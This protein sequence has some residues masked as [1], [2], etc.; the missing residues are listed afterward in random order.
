MSN[1]LRPYGLYSPR[2]NRQ[3]CVL[4]IPSVSDSYGHLI[5]TLF[6][7]VKFSFILC[8]LHIRV[9]KPCSLPHNMVGTPLPGL[10]TSTRTL[11]RTLVRALVRRPGAIMG[12][13]CICI[14][15]SAHVHLNVSVFLCV[16][17]RVPVHVYMCAYMCVSVC[18][19]VGLY[20]CLC[21]WRIT[22]C[23]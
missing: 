21:G 4:R 5:T 23:D 11:F 3:F 16:C 8:S 12:G 17:I 2:L 22:V 10:H 1:S 14:S 20:V 15:V 6:R 13:V 18:V 7:L 9:L 19:S